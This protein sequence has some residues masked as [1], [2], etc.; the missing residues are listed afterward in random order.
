M[1]VDDLDGLQ[2]PLHPPEGR[3]LRRAKDRTLLL[4]QRSWAMRSTSGL[5]QRWTESSPAC[6]RQLSWLQGLAPSETKK[7]LLGG[8]KPRLG[9][10]TSTVITFA[11][12]S[13][14]ADGTTF[15]RGQ[16]FRA[17]GRGESTGQRQ[18]EVTGSEPGVLFYTHI[19]RPVRT[20]LHRQMVN[21]GVARIPPIC[22]RRLAHV[23]PRVDLR[24]EEHYTDTAGFT[25]ITSSPLICTWLG[26]AAF[27]RASQTSARRH[28]CY[29]SA[30]SVQ[31]DIGP[32]GI[33]TVNRNITAM[34]APTWTTSCGLDSFD[35]AGHRQL[36]A[37]GW[38]KA[39][40]ATRPERL[41]VAL[42]EL[43]E[44]SATLFQSSGTWTCKA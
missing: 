20:V 8:P 33:G 40:A 16:R 15:L 17:G 24:I 1:D 43:A 41:A 21:V 5:N 14:G 7:Q 27:A 3:F 13:T 39:R 32:H 11:R 25:R 10:T 29:C 35:Q 6:L 34:S 37:D 26:Y 31:D 4:V 44:L 22:A 18:P 30:N 2:P 9:A 28:C 42:R 36:L 19:S 12:S 38:R 23:Y